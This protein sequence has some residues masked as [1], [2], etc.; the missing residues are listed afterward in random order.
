M[1]NATERHPNATVGSDGY[2][3]MTVTPSTPG[4]AV[5]AARYDIANAKN[6]IQTIENQSHA[7][8]RNH[9]L[10]G[11]RKFIDVI[12]KC[13]VVPKY[14]I[15]FFKP[16]EYSNFQINISSFNMFGSFYLLVFSN[17]S[18][19]ERQNPKR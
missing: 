1:R 2:L 16:T 12:S 18:Q 14:I 9:H 6:K 11:H 4:T 5:P 7:T 13:I 3:H 17:N 19:K 10:Y 15:F 8:K